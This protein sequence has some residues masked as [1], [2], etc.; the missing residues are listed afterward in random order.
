MVLFVKEIFKIIR[1]ITC[2]IFNILVYDM[3]RMDLFS[4]D[5]WFVRL[6][7]SCSATSSGVFVDL[8]R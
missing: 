8:V 3:S 2:V 5:V 6:R 1:I 7:F 4:C